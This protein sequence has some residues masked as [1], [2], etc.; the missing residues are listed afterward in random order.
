MNTAPAGDG[1]PVPSGIGAQRRLRAL[2]ARAWSP[3]TIEQATS[4]PA[5]ATRRMLTDRRRV[6]TEL[7]AAVARAYDQLWNTEPPRASAA[8]KAAADT[9]QEHAERCGWPPPMAYDDDTID[10]PS[11]D[12]GPG[13]KR[14]S[15]TAIPAADLAE[16]VRWLREQGGYRH[17]TP[18][19]LAMRLGVSKAALDKA[20]QRAG[21]NERAAG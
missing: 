15:R 11:G 6:S 21:R 14:T 8:D 3:K 20:L 13:W 17:A 16:D 5:A 10:L 18:A 7:A 9:H 12:P 2:I 19:E 4:L 1:S